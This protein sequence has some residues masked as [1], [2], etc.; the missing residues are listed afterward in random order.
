MS[1]T[2]EKTKEEKKYTW[3][4]IKQAIQIAYKEDSHR[5]DWNVQVFYEP[6]IISKMRNILKRKN[7]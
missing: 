3:K 7:N 4:Q 2:K 5:D 1:H 6:S